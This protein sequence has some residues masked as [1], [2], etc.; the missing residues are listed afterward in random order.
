MKPEK[1]TIS[2][3]G[4]Y[5]KTEIIDFTLL[6][7]DG[8]YLIT[9]DTGA[10]KTTIFDAITY[11]LYGEASGKERE[12]S[13]LRSKHASPSTLTE[14][15]LTFISGD[16][17]YRVK[18]NPEYDR[19][20]ARGEGLT[21][22]KAGAELYLPDGRVITR[23][24]EVGEKINEILGIDKEQFKRI[25]MLAQGRFREFLIADTDSKVSIFRKIF[26]TE[27]YRKIQRAVKE[28]E[29][30]L[31]AELRNLRLSFMQYAD[32]VICNSSELEEAVSLAKST[33]SVSGDIIPL[34]SELVEFDKTREKELNESIKTLENNIKKTGELV[35]ECQ[36]AEE[37]KENVSKDEEALSAHEK[38]RELQESVVVD[39]NLAEENRK[40]AERIKADLKLYSECDELKSTI[41]TI[42]SEIEKA[43][44]FQ[45]ELDEKKK[46][47]ISAIE[48]AE[49]EVCRI[50]KVKEK[51]NELDE[52]IRD[53]TERRGRLEKIIS[54]AEDK[55]STQEKYN[56]S[57][58]EYK[59]A[60]AKAERADSE[61]KTANRLYLDS[62]AGV[63]AATLSDNLPCPVCG[64]LSHP[65]PAK[66]TFE[67]LDM[68]RV[69]ILREESEIAA[70]K[71]LES[72]TNCALL[73]GQYNEKEATLQQLIIEYGN[74]G[75]E[76]LSLF[77]IKLEGITRELSEMVKDKEV[78]LNETSCEMDIAE[79]L[80]KNREAVLE[81]DRAM[82][83]IGKN[84]ASLNLKK[85]I[86]D[87]RLGEISTSLE[88]KTKNEAEAVTIEL[89]SEYDKIL[90]C[91]AKKDDALKRLDS[92][93]TRLRGAIDTNKAR[94][95][96]I[97]FEDLSLLNYKN[98]ELLN[99]KAQA[100]EELTKVSVSIA[101]NRKILLSLEKT[102]REIL[103]V[104][105]KLG[106]I[107]ELSDTANGTV[108]GKEKVT[109]ETY[110][111][112]SFFDGVIA[113]AN[114][115]LLT[116][117]EGRYELVRQKKA[118]NNR[119]QTGLDINVLDHYSATE[120]SAKSLSGGESFMASLALALGLSDEISRSSGGVRIETM[121][122]DEGFGSLDDESLNL[123][124]KTLLSIG[125]N[126][127]VGII[128]HVHQ[129][130]ERIDN[131]I[132]VKKMKDGSST[133][134]I[135]V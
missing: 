50:A 27:L 134:R 31:S 26:G 19:P 60:R 57:L 15:E 25:V 123:A 77:K 37:L 51:I 64:S 42:Q 115:R 94:L 23:L 83:E 72:S 71:L 33:A 62:Q 68:A 116:L 54:V 18:R 135:E 8:V 91:Q 103:R 76:D 61:Y 63:L 80:E 13:M 20:K 10:G 35:L 82:L 124:V 122:I 43:N 11:A 118:I 87:A 84:L 48:T 127:Q 119:S 79:S 95:S 73:L 36:I 121:F 2:A 132:I 113:R 133:T 28:D 96:K 102:N 66:P 110:V 126:K 24:S 45:V 41:A 98:R 6:G 89:L 29:L 70:R 111:L 67:A 44:A 16:K 120:R 69:D 112:T 131:K 40:R 47:L 5:S 3:F 34:A 55:K 12:V 108:S 65:N 21:R 53:R 105:E 109:L 97:S 78:L 114:L 99:K 22:E 14:V 125:E 86:N 117:T 46:T 4:P 85:E 101:T 104:E 30:R 88:Y 100:M 39:L 75:E 32:V 74:P 17:R 92:E 59:S 1:L 52:K 56:L 107:K 129:L 128:S 9:G 81:I 38:E 7:K 90:G 49:G 106:G 130:R 58:V 93:I